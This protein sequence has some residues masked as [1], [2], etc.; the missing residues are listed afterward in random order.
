MI[1]WRGSGLKTT[2]GMEGAGKQSLAQGSRDEI[3]TKSTAALMPGNRLANCRCC[4]KAGAL[5]ALSRLTPSWT[6]EFLV[7]TRVSFLLW[8][9]PAGRDPFPRPVATPGRFGWPEAVCPGPRV[10]LRLSLVRQRKKQAWKGVKERANAG[11]HD[12]KE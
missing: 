4:F 1:S 12:K 5:I 10:G 11:V 2:D 7:M 3:A 6:P 8:C 9:R